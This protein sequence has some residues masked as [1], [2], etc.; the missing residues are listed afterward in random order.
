MSKDYKESLTSTIIR[1]AKKYNELFDDYTGH[2]SS[3]VV[4]ERTEQFEDWTIDELNGAI[5]RYMSAIDAVK[6]NL[7]KTKKTSNI[8][9]IELLRR[10]GFIV[11]EVDDNRGHFSYTIRKDIYGRHIA[12]QFNMPY[13]RTLMD[14]MYELGSGPQLFIS[15]IPPHNIVYLKGNK[16]FYADLWSIVKEEME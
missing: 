8:K 12:A 10:N 15:T 13:E 14:Y 6:K 11:D 5:K 7:H 2:K 16:L 3:V 4:S 9:D 1:L